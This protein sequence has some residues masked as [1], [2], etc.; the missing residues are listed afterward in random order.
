[1]TS[2]PASNAETQTTSPEIVPTVE[3]DPVVLVA[4]VVVVVTSE[5]RTATTA[6][7]MVICPENAQPVV[8]E[9]RLEVV[10]ATTAARKAIFPE[11]ALNQESQEIPDHSVVVVVVVAEALVD[12][13]LASSVMKKDI[14]LETAQTLEMEM[15]QEEK[16]AEDLDLEEVEVVVVV[17]EADREVE[18]MRS[19]TGERKET[20]TSK[21]VLLL[22]DMKWQS[23]FLLILQHVHVFVWKEQDL[24]AFMH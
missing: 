14:W 24:M 12:Q 17:E 16:L 23:Y 19:V 22:I 7:K 11:I 20:T 10:R 13:R 3:A 2:V 4:A 5:R 9:R 21:N 8:V 18:V 1:V 15:D 6:V